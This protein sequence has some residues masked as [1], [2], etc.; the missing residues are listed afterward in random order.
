M[1]TFAAPIT[2]APRYQYPIVWLSIVA[3]LLYFCVFREENDID[4]YLRDNV[5]VDPVKEV[6]QLEQK[7]EKEKAAGLN[8]K[9]T[10]MQLEKVRMLMDGDRQ[11][12]D[13]HLLKMAEAKTANKS[14][15]GF[16]ES[17]KK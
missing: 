14:V 6:S 10:E 8:T 17:F 5:I 13:R 11:V 4:D 16:Q 7:L 2:D 12:L 15:I 3:F 1:D 9:K